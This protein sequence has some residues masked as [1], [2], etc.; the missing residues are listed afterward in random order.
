MEL[1]QFRCQLDQTVAQ[2]VHDVEIAV[3]E[4]STS[5]REIQARYRAVTAAAAEI[6][7][8]RIDG[9]CWQARNRWQGCFSRTSSGPGP[10]CGIRIRIRDAQVS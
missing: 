4:V 3:R 6:R 7:A 10:A 8:C 9:D 1:Y 2:I 5:Y